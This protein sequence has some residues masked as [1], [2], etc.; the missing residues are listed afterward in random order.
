MIIEKNTPRRGFTLVELLTVIAIIGIL[1]AILIPTVGS[2]M[3]NA[4]KSAAASNLRQIGSAYNIYTTG[5]SR[6]RTINEADI[7]AWAAVLAKNADLNDPKI[8]LLGDD[9]AVAS[10]T[11]TFPVVVAAPGATA[12]DPWAP[13]GDFITYP[14]SFAVVNS[15][16]ARASSTAPVAWT[17]GLL[18]SGLWDTT[19][20]GV[21]GEEGGHIVFKDGHV[22]FFET[23]QG[24]TGAGVLVDPVSRTPTANYEEAIGSGATVYQD[25]VQ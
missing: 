1:A 23:T 8:W 9:D 20:Q 22:E 7:N 11:S 15:L 12:A 24:E 16:S 2:V 18:T 4:R 17:R 5:G 10:E 3:D 14:K 21:Y 13:D 25:T 6:P 19:P